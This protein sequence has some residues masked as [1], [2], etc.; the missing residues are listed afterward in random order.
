MKKS[1][2]NQDPSY[3]DKYIDL[4]PDIEL[5]EAIDQYG[6]DYYKAALPSLQSLGDKVYAEGKWTI[7]QIVQHLIDTERIFQYRALRFARRDNV[8]LPGFD[9]DQFAKAADV[10]KRK[11]EDLLDEWKA[12]NASGKALFASFTGEDLQS[13]GVAFNSNI[14]VLSIGF[15]MAGHAIHHMNIISERYIVKV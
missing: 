2:I 10:S 3:F 9:E 4:V 5:S 14:S 1:H 6:S 11:L 15:I 8:L 13:K 7:K 12:V